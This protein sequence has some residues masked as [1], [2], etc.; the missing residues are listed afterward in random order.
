MRIKVFYVALLMVTGVFDVQAQSYKKAAD[1]EAY[2]HHL[3]YAD[4]Q[5]SFFTLPSDA[6]T[7][8]TKLER[9]YHWLAGRQ[10]NVTSGG[11]SGKL[12]HGSFTSFY[13]DKQLKEQGDF[14]K[15]LK[16][17]EWKKWNADGSLASRIHYSNGLKNGSF[18]NYNEKGIL[19]EQG[20][21]SDDKLSGKL[22]KQV[23]ADSV[24]VVRYR[25]G[26]EYQKGGK[27]WWKFWKKRIK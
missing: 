18:Y 26:I 6:K 8:K 9:N 19:I 1:L 14:K 24:A 25:N 27:P 4:Y 15:G 10:I 21:Y 11:Y 3:S 16:Q 5:V 17:G 12:L 22:R 7:G 2:R 23:N 13:L 20:N